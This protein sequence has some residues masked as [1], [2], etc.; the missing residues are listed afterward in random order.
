MR[1]ALLA[2]GALALAAALGWWALIWWQRAMMYP[3]P[4]PPPDGAKAPGVEVLGLG[5]GGD[6]EAWLLAAEGV[7]SPAP[8]MLFF[9]GNGELVDF[10]REDFRAVQSWGV[11][12]LLVEYPGYGRSGGRPSQRSIERVAVAAWD[13]LAARPE[14]DAG[15]IVAYGRSLGGTVACRLARR[16]ELAALVLESTFLSAPAMARELGF[17]GWIVVDRFDCEEALPEYEGPTL[18]LHGEHDRI[19]P[20]SHARRLATIARRPLLVEL[21]CGHNDCPRPWEEIRGFLATVLG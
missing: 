18:I 10:W 20:P 12:V 2:L 14:V 11:S 7:S 21:P 6:V 19:V 8:A 15:R 16:R 17:P 1:A 5:P 4:A 13:A 3:R 9:H